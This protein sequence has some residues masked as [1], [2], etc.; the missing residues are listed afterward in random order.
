MRLLAKQ[1]VLTIGALDRTQIEAVFESARAARDNPSRYARALAGKSGILIFEKPSL[2]TRVTFEVGLARL[3]G[4]PVYF[5]HSSSR[6]GEREP[7]RDYAKNLERWV[8]VIVARVFSHAAVEELAAH[9]SIPVINALSD[10]HHP[11]QALADYLTLADHFGGLR[12][13][14]LAY[15]GDGNNVCHSLMQAGAAL[16]VGVTVVCPKGYEPDSALVTEAQ[17]TASAMGC[18]VVIGNDPE[19]VQGH[20]AIY[21]DTWVSMGDE[22]ES[23]ARHRAFRPYQVDIRRLNAAGSGAVFM[24][25]L[26]AHRGEEVTAEVIDSPRSLVYDQAENRLHVQNGLL[27]HLLGRSDVTI[28]PGSVNNPD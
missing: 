23:A 21:A 1:D 27:L 24:H 4:H 17:R 14:R 11:C 18:E 12:G 16:G 5:D 25:C 20:Q 3:G 22:H 19:M 7:I 10:L 6:L 15:V 13:L 9:A 26:P 28:S 8:D 2:R